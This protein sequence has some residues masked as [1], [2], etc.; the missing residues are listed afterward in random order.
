M[1]NLILLF[2]VVQFVTLGCSSSPSE[3]TATGGVID[4]DA[5][6]FKAK[7]SEPNTIVL[8]V[9]TPAEIA[10]GKI[11]GAFDLDIQ[12]PDFKAQV[13]KLDKA[14][15]YLIYCKRGGRSARACSIFEDAG[16]EKVYNL[17]GGYDGW[18]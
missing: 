2:L 8:D 15:T 11:D 12:N 7:M 5:K 3:S 13:D 16:F 1:K 14:K 4:L 10:A 17:K 9:R 18:K 6:A